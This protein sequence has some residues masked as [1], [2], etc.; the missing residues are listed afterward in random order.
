MIV[1]CRPQ[2]LGLFSER[3][4]LT[5][6][7]P[8]PTRWIHRHSKQGGRLGV[9]RPAIQSNDD[10]EPGFQQELLSATRRIQAL[11]AYRQLVQQSP[12]DID[13]FQ[14]A[15]LIAKH[16]HP[17]LDEAKCYNDLNEQVKAI[18]ASLPSSADQPGFELSYIT[19]QLGQIANFTGNE[20]DYYDPDNS[21][22]NMVLQRQTG[23]PITLGLLYMV[24][25]HRLGLSLHGLNLPGHLMVGNSIEG[26]TNLLVD[27][28]D[29]FKLLNIP[30][31]EELFAQRYSTKLRLSTDLV[32]NSA[33]V[34]ST[35]TMLVRVLLNLKSIYTG[36]QQADKVLQITDYL[37]ATR[38]FADDVR[39]AGLCLFSMQ[40]YTDSAEVLQQYLTQ[41]P[42][43]QDRPQ[44]EAVLSR[45][46]KLMQ[47]PNF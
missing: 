44:V 16:R 31:V 12:A 33:L 46:Y 42:Y 25:A 8:T 28:F 43:A 40:R 19:R 34:M 2:H 36:L 18:Q 24:V 23:I 29:G 1:R 13:L 5:R 20:K 10:V 21:C 9:V 11:E 6:F 41:S 17:L 37:R 15:L 14:A 38:D 35:P 47:K 7:L 39:D 27:P 22:M 32:T 26:V 30:Q 4:P 3:C 45:I